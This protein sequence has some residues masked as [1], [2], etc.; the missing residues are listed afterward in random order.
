MAHNYTIFYQFGRQWIERHQFQSVNQTVHGLIV[1]KIEY[2]GK[3][4]LKY[5][6]IFTH[7]IQV[8]RRQKIN[9][10]DGNWNWSSGYD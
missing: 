3:S 8:F 7:N 9:G 6:F 10:P 1:Y 5:F 2:H 4:K